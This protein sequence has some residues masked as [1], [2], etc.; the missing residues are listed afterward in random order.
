MAVLAR[1]AETMETIAKMCMVVVGHEQRGEGGL[2]VA[3]GS[4]ESEGWEWGGSGTE[5]GERLL[6]FCRCESYQQLQ[7]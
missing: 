4:C 6:T 1:S 7:D 3:L 5:R 2:G